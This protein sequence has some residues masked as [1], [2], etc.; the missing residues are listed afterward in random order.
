M[1]GTKVFGDDE[2]LITA[3]LTYAQL[4]GML[5]FWGI[6]SDWR[7]NKDALIGHSQLFWNEFF[8]YPKWLV[9]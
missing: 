5:A 7:R 9:S 4:V 1:P 6:E 2:I 8:Q 3:W